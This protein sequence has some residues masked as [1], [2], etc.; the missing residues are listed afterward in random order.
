MFSFSSSL[1]LL[2]VH[3]QP[4]AFLR[5]GAFQVA[6]TIF[7]EGE[8]D[9]DVFSTTFFNQSILVVAPTDTK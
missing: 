4:K 1:P 9:D 8:G 2:N 5:P 3:L 6:H 7:Y